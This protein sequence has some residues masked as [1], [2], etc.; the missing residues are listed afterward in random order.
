MTISSNTVGHPVIKVLVLSKSFEIGGA[1][2]MIADLALL[3]E[4]DDCSY[5]YAYLWPLKNDVFFQLIRSAGRPVKGLGTSKSEL[6]IRW[7]FRLR[8]YLK[9]ARFDV[10]HTHAA[11]TSSLVRL[12]CLTLRHRPFQVYTEHSVWETSRFLTNI[13]NRLTLPLCDALVAVSA[14]TAASYPSNYSKAFSVVPPGISRDRIIGAVDQDLS[15]RM[16]NLK[17]RTS[18]LVGTA[19]RLVPVKNVP[20]LISAIA[21]LRNSGHSVGCVIAGD[22]PEFQSLISLVEELDL[23]GLVL[24]LGYIEQVGAM[25]SL[26]DAFVLSSLHEGAPVSIMEAMAAGVPVIA[27]GVDGV[28]ELFTDGQE[29]YLIPINNPTGIANAVSK[30]IENPDLCASLGE[31]ASQ[32]SRVYN[33]VNTRD[34][35]EVIYKGLFR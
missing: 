29:G 17:E 10:I 27:T 20:V 31:A 1:E 14:F 25:L 28:N 7:L 22:G 30:L 16:Q 15:D 33:I 8:K 21:S 32:R 13:A 9:R 2:R 23:S 19:A 11:S 3:P 35:L 5:E 26:I 4:T 18:F 34:A 24:F 6:D 12:V